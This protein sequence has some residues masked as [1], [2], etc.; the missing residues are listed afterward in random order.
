MGDNRSDYIS[1]EELSMEPVDTCSE[2]VSDEPAS[3][4]RVAEEDSGKGDASDELQTVDS[5]YKVCSKDHLKWILVEALQKTGVSAQ[6]CCKLKHNRMQGFFTG[7]SQKSL[8]LP[9][10]PLLSRLPHWRLC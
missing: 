10:R 8:A 9:T 2:E 6:I 4:H 3:A 5:V 1:P 7:S